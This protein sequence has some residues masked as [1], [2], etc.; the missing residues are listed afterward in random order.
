MKVY[1]ITGNLVYHRSNNELL[2]TSPEWQ[3][4]YGIRQWL[5]G[6]NRQLYFVWG[7]LNDRRMRCAPGVYR[8]I[9]RITIELDTEHAGRQIYRIA[10]KA[11]NMGVR[12]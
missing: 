10:P 3:A 8:G 11:L 2:S 12:K 7:G 5:E 1:D 9:A 6:E 4:E